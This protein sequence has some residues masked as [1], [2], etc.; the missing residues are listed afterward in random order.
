MPCKG[1]RTELLVTPPTVTFPQAFD[2]R[3]AELLMTDA[4]HLF[5]Q[6]ARADNTHLSFE[7]QFFPPVQNH[8]LSVN[9]RL[10]SWSQWSYSFDCQRGICVLCISEFVFCLFQN[11]CSVY[12]RICVLCIS[13]LICVLCVSEC[14]CC[15][16]QNLCSECFRICVLCVSVFVC[17]VFQNLGAVNFRICV[18]C[19]S[20][21]VFCV[22]KNLCVVYFRQ[23]SQA[24]LR[25]HRAGA[26][27]S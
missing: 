17:W 24:A 13:E 16:F 7:R 11:L 22:F 4:I 8:F 25:H 23:P 6:S 10:A 20:E 14:V 19:V 3:L 9:P 26:P 5:S 1:F 15:V 21:F 2:L 18:L 12:F 27:Q